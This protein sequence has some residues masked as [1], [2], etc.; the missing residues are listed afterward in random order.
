MPEAEVWSH[1]IQIALGLKYLH[2]H[3]ILHRWARRGCGG[4]CGF[5]AGPAWE[6]GRREGC[7]LW[8]SWG[9]GFASA[10]AA[11]RQ[12]KHQL[13]SPALPPCLPER[14]DLKPQNILLNDEGRLK[15]ADLGVSAP[16]AAG[17]AHGAQRAQRGGGRRRSRRA[18]TPAPAGYVNTAS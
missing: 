1:F 5:G 13:P 12:R 4:G 15:I 10:S 8:G 3:C 14:R 2:V 9:M 11:A 6:A 7:S 18:P 16:G 17:L